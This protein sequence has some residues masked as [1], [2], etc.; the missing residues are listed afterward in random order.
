[1][2]GETASSGSTAP[3]VGWIANATVALARIG[4]DP[5][6]TKS[7]AKEG[8]PC[9]ACRSDLARGACNAVH[10][11][12]RVRLHTEEPDRA[13]PELRHAVTPSVSSTS[14]RST[15]SASSGS[16]RIASPSAHKPIAIRP[17]NEIALTRSAWC[18]AISASE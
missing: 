9:T 5:G 14:D 8:A 7:C 16:S 4:A 1:M 15:P 11:A 18:G 10:R 3:K 13:H 17:A 6:T 2:T 12:C